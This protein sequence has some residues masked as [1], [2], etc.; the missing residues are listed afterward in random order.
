MRA[1]GTLDWVSPNQTFPCLRD[2]VRQGWNVEALNCFFYQ[3]GLPL[4]DC[5]TQAGMED[6][7]ILI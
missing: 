2:A 7:T 3:R 5:D 4:P 6:N 1:V